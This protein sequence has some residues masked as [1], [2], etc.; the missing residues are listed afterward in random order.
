MKNQLKEALAAI[1]ESAATAKEFL[2]EQTPLVIQELLTYYTIMYAFWV[3]LGTICFMVG[4]YLVICVVQDKR[5]SAHCNNERLSKNQLH[6]YYRDGDYRD[7]TGKGV[8]YIFPGTIAMAAGMILFFCNISSL[9]KI[10]IAPKVWL[11]EY[12]SR[13]F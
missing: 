9:F 11:I 3:G 13:L 5:P 8:A 1:I 10:T 4:A 12:G 2:V 7:L 6:E